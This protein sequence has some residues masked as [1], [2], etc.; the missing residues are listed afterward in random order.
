M[1]FS[2]RVGLRVRI[3][4]WLLSCHAHVFV[5]LW[6]VIFTYLV[7]ILANVFAVLRLLT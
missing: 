2:S 3:S 6:V 5:Q 7:Y 4:F 1:L